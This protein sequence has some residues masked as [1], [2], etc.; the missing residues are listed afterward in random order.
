MQR[1]NSNKFFILILSNPVLETPQFALESIL[2][3]PLPIELK[4][5]TNGVC[6]EEIVTYLQVFASYITA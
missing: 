6:W 4:L 2:Y 5:R 3:D 1:L